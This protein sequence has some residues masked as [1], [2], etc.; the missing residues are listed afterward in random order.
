MQIPAG[1]LG[2]FR[3]DDILDLAAQRHGVSLGRDLDLA[4]GNPRDRGKDDDF[5][6]GG[7]DIE[8]KLGAGAVG[9]CRPDTLGH[10]GSEGLVEETIDRVTNTEHCR[11]IPSSHVTHPFHDWN[12]SIIPLAVRHL[13]LDG[14]RIGDRS[15]P[16]RA[17]PFYNQDLITLTMTCQVSAYQFRKAQLPILLVPTHAWERQ[18]LIHQPGVWRDASEHGRCF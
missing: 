6:A 8:R 18:G 16:L 17:H 1:I 12:E 4:R 14:A 11:R 7:I 15:L 2:L 9:A 10:P 5:I 13:S 3:L